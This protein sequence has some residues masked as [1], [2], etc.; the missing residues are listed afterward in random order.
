MERLRQIFLDDITKELVILKENSSNY[1]LSNFFQTELTD[2]ITLLH[3]KN[4]DKIIVEALTHQG[5]P[6]D[7]IEILDLNTIR[8]N[9]ASPISGII[10]IITFE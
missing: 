6:I 4:T 8:I 10:N 3:S 5:T 1:E 9:F 7:N 2:S